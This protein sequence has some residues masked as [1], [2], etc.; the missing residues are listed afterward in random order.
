[1]QFPTY[2]TRGKNFAGIPT[3]G[4]D[5]APTVS[6]GERKNIDVV[7]SY[8]PAR[9]VHRFVVG[10]WYE[11]GGAAVTLPV[12]IWVFDAASKKWFQSGSGTLTNG[13]LTAIRIPR[14]TD[15][16]QTAANIGLPTMAVDAMIVIADN[17]APDGRY[18]FV[19]GPDTA[20]F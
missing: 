15:P 16:P 17:T 19:A 9:D 12:G 14:L 4:S 11:G 5:P 7:C 2:F 8:K 6:T 1:M 3:L 10:Y 20:I 18:H 13:Q